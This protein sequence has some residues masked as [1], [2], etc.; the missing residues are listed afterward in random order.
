MYAGT[1]LVAFS[2]TDELQRTA[3]DAAKRVDADR[4]QSVARPGDGSRPVAR[5]A[6][7]RLSIQR[8]VL[9]FTHACAYTRRPCP[10]WVEQSV[11]AVRIACKAAAYR[12]VRHHEVIGGVPMRHAEAAL[13]RVNKSCEAARTT[14]L[15]AT[16]RSN[17]S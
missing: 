13:A 2:P 6:R 17:V 15:R 8:A 1:E 7:G 16:P 14:P 9:L 11:N 12:L 4:L 3:D 5:V 10:A